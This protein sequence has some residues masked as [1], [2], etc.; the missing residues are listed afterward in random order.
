MRGCIYA[1]YSTDKQDKK[2]TEDQIQVCRNYAKVHNIEVVQIY[3]DEGYSGYIADRPALKQMLQDAKE[4]LWDVLLVEHTSR[5]ARDGLLLRKLIEEFRFLFKKPIIF[6]SQGLRT[7]RQEDIAVIKLF[8]LIDENYIEGIRIA[9]R[10]GLEGS[11]LQGKWVSRPP[12]GYRMENGILQI[13]ET[14][15]EIVRFIFT[16][17]ANG[18]GIRS[19]TYELNK[20]GIKPRYA[21]TWSISTLRNIIQNP[22]Y[23]G[24]LIW[25]MKKR[26][27][28][29]LTGKTHFIPQKPVSIN[30]PELA[31]VSEEVWQKANEKLQQTKKTNI[32]VRKISP[33]TGIVICGVC[34]KP[35]G[36]E[37]N[38]LVCLNY[39]NKKTCTNDIRLD[40]DF[41][42]R[43]IARYVKQFLKDNK[44]QLLEIMAKQQNMSLDYALLIQKQ[45]EKLKHLYELYAE[46]PSPVLREKIKE[47]ETK[48]LQLQQHKH[49]TAKINIDI[50]ALIDNLESIMLKHPEEANQSLK[51]LLEGVVVEPADGIVRIN[52]LAS[53][54]LSTYIQSSEMSRAG[55]VGNT[56]FWI[57]C[58]VVKGIPI[59]IGSTFSE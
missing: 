54:Y 48:L 29:K 21:E 56:L 28:D 15:A 31:I 59:P 9:T 33:L 34:G 23:K 47:E 57:N 20:N 17:Y 18:M 41:M 40:Y 30:M 3:R 49:T 58:E 24:L 25:G 14:E 55:F 37:D 51:L 43:F 2:S 38:K 46:A 16:Q 36:K 13:H 39:R 1:R 6:V 26:Y 53:P 32:P 52:F 44:A 7:D 4:N 35:M 12:Y 5:L 11:L 10:R 27:I 50:D 42:L 8:N 19:I 22:I 45:E